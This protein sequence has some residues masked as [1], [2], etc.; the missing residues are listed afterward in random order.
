M[1]VSVTVLLI[2]VAVALVVI[3][4][5]NDGGVLMAMA[6]RYTVLPVGWLLL[7]L[8]AILVSGP[9]ITTT[10]AQTL[11][12]G[13]FN[14]SGDELQGPFLVGVTI[15]IIVVMVLSF[16][17]LPTSL[18]LALVGGLSGAGLGFGTPMSWDMVTK[19][20]LVGMAAPF[21]G[22][23]LGFVF[24]RLG[25]YVPAASQTQDRLARAHVIAF[26]M[27]GFAYSINDGQKMLAVAAIALA[28]LPGT[29]DLF[30]AGSFT[31]RLVTLIVM[32][33]LFILGMLW[34]VRRVSS[35]LGLGLATVSPH[36]AVVAEF[37]STFAVM[38]S[39][40][41]G[42]PVSM[43][44]SASAGIM[45]TAA[46]KGVRRVRWEVAAKMGVAWVV[47]LPTSGAVAYLAAG[48]LSVLS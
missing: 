22:G 20:L 16:L 35:R 47:T 29:Y 23:I 21:V 32:G 36:D 37:A 26:T 34:T 46:S 27:Q 24:E 43:S 38:G 9:L 19:V 5:A 45:G 1:E 3:S 44:Q 7:V 42:V 8:G 30:G 48:V 6:L 18:T 10:V 28:S 40:A 17:G 13:I 11:T 31:L 41:I 25:R 14:S 4:G 15:A 39:S 33:L 12:A 2:L